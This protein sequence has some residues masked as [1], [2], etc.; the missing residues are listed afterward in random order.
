MS[1]KYSA[2]IREILS[3]FKA[4]LDVQISLDLSSKP[5]PHKWSKKEI[6]GHLIDSAYHNHKRFL[7][8]DKKGDLI[9]E[10][11]DQNEWVAKNN[12]QNR[13]AKEVIALFLVVNFHI[14][15]LINNID[16]GVLDYMTE[17]HNFDKICMKQVES[18]GPVSLRYLVEDYIFHLEHHLNQI[19][20]W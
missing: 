17:T 9:F 16:E 18:G 15:D 1:N 7:R 8:A 3:R 14:S 6:L 4:Y 11:Y 10:G 20:V 5:L 2:K 13:D 19:I 12:Y